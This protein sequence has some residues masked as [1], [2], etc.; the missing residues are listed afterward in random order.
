MR[1]SIRA[2]LAAAATVPLMLGFA[3]PAAL[4]DSDRAAVGFG[5]LYHDGEVVRTVV[6]PT[7]TPGR[8]V[9]A[10]YAVSGGVDGQL[11][12][13]SV[14]PGEPGYHGGRWAV[15]AVSWNAGVEPYLLVSDEAVLAAAQ[16]GEVSIMRVA[17]ADFVCPVAGR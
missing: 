4:A 16:A 13:T 14:A 9:D 6:T 7:S 5:S 10:I 15:H 1:R 8:G 12:V 17:A 2:V 11:A 3:A